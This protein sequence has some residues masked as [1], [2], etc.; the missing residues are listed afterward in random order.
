MPQLYEDFMEI[1]RIGCGNKWFY[2]E[3]ALAIERGWYRFIPA[4]HDRDV[5]LARFW[6]TTPVKAGST[7]E[8]AESLLLHAF[9][10][11]DDDDALHSHDWPF[12]TTILN[13]GYTEAMPPASWDPSSRL[14]PP[15]MENIIERRVGDTV[16]HEGTSFHSVIAVQPFTWTLVRVGKRYGKSWGFHPEGQEFVPWRTYLNIPETE[17]DS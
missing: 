4:R 9:A 5:Y 14:G 6:L 2:R 1:Q 15:M 8:S 12:E 10:R 7:W 13:G 3:A 16:N 11:P 17:H